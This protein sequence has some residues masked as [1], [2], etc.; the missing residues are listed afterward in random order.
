MMYHV[1][2]PLDFTLVELNWLGGLGLDR[3][4]NG[5]LWTDGF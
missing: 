4:V 5:F 2:H 3:L 1:N